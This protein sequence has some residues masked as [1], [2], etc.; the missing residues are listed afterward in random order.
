MT[1]EYV[2]IRYRPKSFVDVFEKTI[3]HLVAR[4]GQSFEITI[5]KFDG[6]IKQDMTTSTKDDDDEVLNPILVKMSKTVGPEY[7]KALLTQITRSV[8]KGTEF[9]TITIPLAK[10]VLPE[11]LVVHKMPV[12][13]EAPTGTHDR[14]NNPKTYKYKLIEYVYVMKVADSEKFIKRYKSTNND[15]DLAEIFETLSVGSA[16]NEDDGMN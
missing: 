10:K 16:G 7:T 4:D 5:P 13:V 14:F 9:E 8:E 6:E 11:S 12:Q 2:G 3:K 1:V 15:D